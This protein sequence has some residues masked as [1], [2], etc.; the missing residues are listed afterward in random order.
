MFFSKFQRGFTYVEGI[1][2]ITL[3]LAASS[4]VAF[5]IQKS[6]RTYKS[7]QL[8]DKAVEALIQYTED[9]RMMVAYGE[10]PFPG[11]QPRGENGHKIVLYDASNEREMS[12]GGNKE[13]VAHGYLFHDIQVVRNSSECDQILGEK[14]EY[15]NIKTWIEWDDIFDKKDDEFT[16]RNR[17]NLAFEVNQAVILN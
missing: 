3:T 6:I 11:K 14:K 13:A 2:A 1:L 15:Y 9:Y 4:A 8:K 12:F 17:K 7:Q 5:G 16:Y 10:T